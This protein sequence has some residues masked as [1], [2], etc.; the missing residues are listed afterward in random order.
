[1]RFK[2]AWGLLIAAIAAIPC[3]AAAAPAH[4]VTVVLS[5]DD[6]AYHETYESFRETLLQSA[7]PA[8]PFEID[9]ITLRDGE[10]G[11]DGK[12]GDGPLPDL[13]IPIGAQAAAFVRDHY[14]ATPV[15]SI[16]ITRPAFAATWPRAAAP[17]AAARPDPPVTALYLEQPFDRQFRLIRL[18]L[19]DVSRSSVLLGRQSRGLEKELRAAARVSGISL[20]I[21]DYASYR[22]PVEAFREV[23]DRGDAVLVFPD[24][25]V[26]TP[27][28][29]KWLLYMAYQKQVPVIGFSR[30]L[31]DA[32]A[33]ATLYTS[34]DQI[35]R[36]AAEQVID[37]A[38]DAIARP[39]QTWRLPPPA[40][41]RYFN[42]AVNRA[43]ARDF[44]IRIRDHQRLARALAEMEQTDTWHADHLPPG[45]GSPGR[46]QGR[47]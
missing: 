31:A 30:A 15:Y 43:V 10:T 17:G 33:L 29:A 38:L 14:P 21:V 2:P 22:N 25:D 44:A 24:A 11:P 6:T 46:L 39:G 20:H 40:W 7:G 1:M 35:G 9:R 8:L 23:L 18:T 36:Q 27:N 37:I 16:L 19:P 41:P 42:V 45:N 34:P 26:I 28:R 3:I 13:V 4:R 12:R 5:D 47:P 32:G